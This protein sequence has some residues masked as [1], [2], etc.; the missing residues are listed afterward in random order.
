LSWG[1]TF[2]G[3][4]MNKNL[5]VG[6]L[7]LLYHF[8]FVING[9]RSKWMA[10]LSATFV[11]TLLLFLDIMFLLAYFFRPIDKIIT[12]SLFAFLFS[13]NC[14][15]FVSKRKFEIHEEKYQG[16]KG[17]YKLLFLLFLIFLFASPYFL[18]SFELKMRN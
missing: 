13:F 14:L 18:G 2:G 5:Y 12:F 1:K 6:S 9:K 15:T 10:A 17:K 7:W 16:I 8:I 11:F 4:L 3:I